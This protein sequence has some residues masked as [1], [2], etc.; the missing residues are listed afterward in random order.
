MSGRKGIPVKLLAVMVA[1]SLFLPAG[2]RAAT[3]ETVQPAAGNYIADAHSEIHAVGGGDLEIYFTVEGMGVWAEIGVLT[4]YVYEST[5]NSNFTCVQTL[6]AAD[7][8][9]MMGGGVQMY[10]NHVDY[11]GVPGC[12]YKVYIMAWVDTGTTGE[13]KY[14]WSEAVRCT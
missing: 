5:D 14:V 1:V 9:E 7:Y 12:Y 10:R 2:A 13:S 6:R 4:I 8:E 3:A 11:E